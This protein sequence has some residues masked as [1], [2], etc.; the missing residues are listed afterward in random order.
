MDTSTFNTMFNNPFGSKAWNQIDTAETFTK[1]YN[2]NTSVEKLCIDLYENTNRIDVIFLIN[3][4]NKIFEKE[5]NCLTEEQLKDFDITT[6][7][8]N[9]KNT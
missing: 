5:F 2:H 9:R 7:S 1:K 6:Q 8:D 4:R 3:R